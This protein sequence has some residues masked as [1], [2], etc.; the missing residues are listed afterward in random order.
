MDDYWYDYKYDL[1]RIADKAETG[2]SI[3]ILR[4]LYLDENSRAYPRN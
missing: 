2:Y 4:K 1:E 3:W